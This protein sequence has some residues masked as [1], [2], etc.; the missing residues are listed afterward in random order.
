MNKVDL[1]YYTLEEAAERWGATGILKQSP[2]SKTNKW[3]TNSF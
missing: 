3:R 2:A 1:G